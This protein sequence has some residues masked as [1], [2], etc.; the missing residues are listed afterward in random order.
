MGTIF[1]ALRNCI[2]IILGASHDNGY[3]RMLRQ[4][5]TEGVT[6]GK[7]VLLE[8]LPFATELEKLIG[9]TFP[10]VKFPG[11]F[12]EQKLTTVTATADTGTKYST[13][14]AHGVSEG[15]PK[16]P[17]AKPAVAVSKPLSRDTGIQLKP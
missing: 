13:V 16:S 10:S 2:R 17:T 4:L 6:P 5:E 7:V 14:A 15:K 1:S 12:M 3:A 8:G 9:T 11:V